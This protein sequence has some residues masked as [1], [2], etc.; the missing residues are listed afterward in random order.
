MLDR[1]TTVAVQSS[2]VN[3]F[4]NNPPKTL[5]TVKQFSH[6]NP[7]FSEGSLRALI[8]NS[9]PRHSTVGEIPG[10]GLSQ[11][12]VRIGRKLLIDE[13]KFYQW[14]ESQD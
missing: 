9:K 10:N 12:I 2:T 5:L 6:R 4:L 8:F 3:T 13:A 14:L 11:A 7:S 1:S